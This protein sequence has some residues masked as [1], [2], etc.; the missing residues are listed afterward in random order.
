MYL[1][2]VHVDGFFKDLFSRVCFK[3]TWS[4]PTFPFPTFLCNVHWATFKCKQC[5][6]TVSE[7]KRLRIHIYI[8]ASPLLLPTTL[9]PHH[10][11]LVC[12][13]FLLVIE[14]QLGK[15]RGGTAGTENHNIQKRLEM[16]NATWAAFRSAFKYKY[17]EGN[18]A[19][20]EMESM[21]R[22]SICSKNII[23]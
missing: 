7:K 1:W 4:K 14:Y 16:E 17:W 5:Y 2:K 9:T 22:T 12:T 10:F 3:L 13:I 18:S 15:S 19:N 11:L 21:E 20:S 8:K 23:H 6:K